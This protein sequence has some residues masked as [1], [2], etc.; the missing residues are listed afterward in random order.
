[1]EREARR[2]LI[3]STGRAPWPR[4]EGLGMRSPPVGLSTEIEYSQPV[5]YKH[6]SLDGGHRR[7]PSHWRASVS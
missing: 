2:R 1:V 5:L 3:T 7:G 4:R 6:F